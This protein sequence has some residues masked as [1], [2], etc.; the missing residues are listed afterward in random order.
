MAVVIQLPRIRKDV[1]GFGGEDSDKRALLYEARQ[2][3]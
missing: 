1:F 2:H 3:G